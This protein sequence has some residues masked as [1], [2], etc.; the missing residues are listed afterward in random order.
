[1]LPKNFKFTLNTET[2]FKQRFVQCKFNVNGLEDVRWCDG[3]LAVKPWLK[4]KL[5]KLKKGKMAYASTFN[6]LIKNY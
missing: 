4:P 2:K 6:L 3:I 5:G 1:M